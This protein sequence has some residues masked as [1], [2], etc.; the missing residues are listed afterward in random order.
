[1]RTANQESIYRASAPLAVGDDGAGDAPALQRMRALSVARDGA[2]AALTAVL[3]LFLFAVAFHSFRPTDLATFD[4]FLQ[5][6]HE[7][8][9]IINH[10]AGR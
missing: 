4:L 2:S 9:E 6:G 10:C 1:M 5:P 8:L 7:W 3:A